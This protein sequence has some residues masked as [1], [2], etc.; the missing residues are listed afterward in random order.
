MKP[1]R[2]TSAWMPIV[3]GWLVVSPVAVP[4]TTIVHIVDVG[5]LVNQGAPE[6]VPE[7]PILLVDELTSVDEPDM[8]TGMPPG[9]AP[10]AGA[11]LVNFHALSRLYLPRI[12]FRPALL[13]FRLSVGARAL[14]S[15]RKTAPLRQE[16]GA[17]NP[18]NEIDGNK[19]FGGSEAGLT[20]LSK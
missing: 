10:D 2:P 7:L 8:P 12:L 17:G 15:G 3:I 14:H 13:T 16:I 19:S 4:A 20:T 5:T 9:P 6:R 1:S 18:G 11:S